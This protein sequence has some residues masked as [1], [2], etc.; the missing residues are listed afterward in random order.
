VF[1]SV[2]AGFDSDHMTLGHSKGGSAFRVSSRTWPLGFSAHEMRPGDDV[3]DGGREVRMERGDVPDRYR[4]LD[5]ADTI[6]LEQV[7]MVLRSGN[8]A[9]EVPWFGRHDTSGK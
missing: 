9:V 4:G 6:V 3:L 8:D 5:H 2:W 7:P 1:S